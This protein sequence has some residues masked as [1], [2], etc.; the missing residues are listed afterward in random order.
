MC[1]NT[2]GKPCVGKGEKCSFQGNW[3]LCN[4]REKPSIF[5]WQGAHRVCPRQDFAQCLSPH[6]PSS[7][8]QAQGKMPPHLRPPLCF[9][10]STSIQL[11]AVRMGCRGCLGSAHCWPSSCCVLWLSPR[12]AL[13]PLPSPQLLALGKTQILGLMWGKAPWAG[14]GTAALLSL[15]H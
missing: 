8:P 4:Q 2:E 7:P 6:K 1:K 15:Q 10:P 11:G 13:L 9:Q 3:T 5:I 14:T 12:A